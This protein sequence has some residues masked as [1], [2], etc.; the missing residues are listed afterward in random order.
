MT[1]RSLVPDEEEVALVEAAS[2][3]QHDDTHV[4]ATQ[5]PELIQ[6][7]AQRRGAEPATGEASTS[8]PATVDVHD[9]DAGIRFNFPGAAPY[10][11]I[12]WVEWFDHFRHHELV[13]VYERDEPEQ[14]PSARYRLLKME[15]L[16]KRAT[17]VA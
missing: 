6:H 14:T 11:P 15:S 2:E 9:G 10:R 1:T 17:V 13:F 4:V 3:N 12:E 5:D 7:W 16:K 8:G